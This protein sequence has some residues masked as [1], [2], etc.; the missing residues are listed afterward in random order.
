MKPLR[1]YLHSALIGTAVGGLLAAAIPG[2]VLLISHYFLISHYVEHKAQDI[3]DIDS[4]ITVWHPCLGVCPVIGALA[5]IIV[6]RF[7]RSRR[8]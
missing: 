3:E 5:G 6:A 2:T 8:V 7:S 1:S 4:F